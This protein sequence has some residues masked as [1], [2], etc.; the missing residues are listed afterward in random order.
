MRRSS[1]VESVNNFQPDPNFR[2]YVFADRHG[3]QNG[4]KKYQ[5]DQPT[6]L[7]KLDKA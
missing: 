2:Q 3:D 6:K 7:G 5:Y 1:D 4:A